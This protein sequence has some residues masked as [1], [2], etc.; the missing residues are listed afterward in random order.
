M[1]TCRQTCLMGRKMDRCFDCQ[2]CDWNRRTDKVWRIFEREKKINNAS[3]PL[4]SQ[5]KKWTENFCL[6]CT[7][8]KRSKLCQKLKNEGCFF[9]HIYIYICMYIY[10]D[11]HRVFIVLL[12]YK[13]QMKYLCVCLYFC[14]LLI[15]ISFFF[16]FFCFLIVKIS[17]ASEK[18]NWKIQCLCFFIGSIFP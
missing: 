13:A 7:L 15:S 9:F 16:C 14:V 6:T 8:L 5:Q 10:I 2:M 18:Q 17:G 1:W 4:F 11:S 3:A 12:V